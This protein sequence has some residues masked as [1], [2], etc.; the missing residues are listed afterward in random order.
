MKVEF[1]TVGRKFLRVRLFRR[2]VIYFQWPVMLGNL[3]NK[4]GGIQ[5]KKYK[6][7][8]EKKEKLSV[9]MKND[10]KRRKALQKPKRKYK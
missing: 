5:R 6:W 8:K 9:Y 4:L 7:S 3:P 10:W 1:T 2:W